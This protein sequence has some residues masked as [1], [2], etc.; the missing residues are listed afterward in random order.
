MSHAPATSE[1][2]RPPRH[3]RRATRRREAARAPVRWMMLIVCCG[4]GALILA[5]ALS[6]RLSQASPQMSLNLSPWRASARI[7]RA[8]DL[9]QDDTQQAGEAILELRAAIRTDP[10]VPRAFA[11]LAQAHEASGDPQSALRA[12]EAA[13][14]ASLRDGVAQAV[15]LE[16]DLKAYAPE[17][18]LERLD[19]LLRGSPEIGQPILQRLTPLL[20]ERRFLEVLAARLEAAPPW[21]R[22]ILIELARRAPE[23]DLIIALHHRLQR[24]P[25]PPVEDEIRPLLMRMTAAGRHEEAYVEWLSSG[26]RDQR[27]GNEWLY[28]ARF[29]APVSNLP[30][31]WTFETTAGALMQVERAGARRLLSVDFFGSRLAFQNVSQWLLLPP[32]AY[33]LSGL[34]R[35]EAIEGDRGVRWRV[36][37]AHD[38]DGALATGT[39]LTG[40]IDWREFAIAFTVPA[41]CRAQRLVLEVPARVVLERVIRGRVSYTGLSLQS[42]PNMPSAP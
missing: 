23:L 10:L 22:P 6:E 19:I 16:R 21:R 38:P 26:R 36:A 40:S 42:T 2:P 29:Q 27:S 15:L 7:A 9:L 37:C 28:N 13:A 4:L 39:A 5:D 41:T 35:A 31:D 8:N 33:V 1:E 25:A 17:A 24:G 11:M 12:W 3:G 18:A 14:R 20:A 32:G 30:F 34:E